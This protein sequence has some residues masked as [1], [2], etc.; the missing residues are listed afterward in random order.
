MTDGQTSSFPNFGVFRIQ[1]QWVLA[2]GKS[3][4]PSGLDAKIQTQ[5]TDQE[6]RVFY[7]ALRALASQEQTSSDKIQLPFFDP[8]VWATRRGLLLTLK[9]VENVVRQLD[10]GQSILEDGSWQYG[11]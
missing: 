6:L 3:A 9:K 8:P 11:N 5:I 1:G 7:T 10:S 4:S 2:W